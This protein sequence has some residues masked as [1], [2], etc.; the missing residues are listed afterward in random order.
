MKGECSSGWWAG[1]TCDHL[2]PDCPNRTK[3]EETLR[4]CGWWDVGSEKPAAVTKS[5]DPHGGDVCGLCLHR[6]N[7]SHHQGGQAA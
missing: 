1:H 5:I 3:A 6:H 7:R 4:Q 2:Y